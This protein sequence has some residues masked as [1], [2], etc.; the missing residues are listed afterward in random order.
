L[1]GKAP[2][3]ARR[4]LLAPGMARKRGA[5]LRLTADSWPR[6]RQPRARM[7][8]ITDTETETHV[9][10]S[11][12][13]AWQSGLFPT[14]SSFGVRCADGPSSTVSATLFTPSVRKRTQSTLPRR[15]RRP[16]KI[17]CLALLSLSLKRTTRA[18]Q[19]LHSPVGHVA[20]H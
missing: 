15:S 17:T 14:A 2:A 12:V 20:L 9:S 1:R 18:D 6:D 8:G 5:K 7:A 13:L 10:R 3:P 11:S 16:S 4:P 19:G